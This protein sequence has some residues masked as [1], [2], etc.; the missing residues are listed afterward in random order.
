MAVCIQREGQEIVNL[1]VQ[2]H[3]LPR[4]SCEICLILNGIS[5]QTLVR[6]KSEGIEAE[7]RGKQIKVVYHFRQPHGFCLAFHN[8][9]RNVGPHSRLRNEVPPT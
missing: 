7:R 8:D 3:K 2:C 5:I 1:N 4:R 9:D 6:R